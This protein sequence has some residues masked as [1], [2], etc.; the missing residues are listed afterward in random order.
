LKEGTVCVVNN[1]VYHNIVEERVKINRLSIT[2]EDEL[3]P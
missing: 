3:I 2:V 1:E